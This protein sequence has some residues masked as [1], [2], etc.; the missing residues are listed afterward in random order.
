MTR[1]RSQTSR[2]RTSA[3]SRV[4][5]TPYD[6]P[7]AIYPESVAYVYFQ[8]NIPH[9]E[10]H[11]MPRQLPVQGRGSF[12]FKR[13]LSSFS[14]EGNVGLVT[15]GARGLGLVMTQALVVSGA[16]VAIVDLNSMFTSAHVANQTTANQIR[17]GRGCQT[18]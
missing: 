8:I 4:Q 13:T 3:P 6:K 16:D 17:R 14:L 1:S 9:P 11:E 2:V 18:S 12:H 5:T 15:G 7:L 10:E